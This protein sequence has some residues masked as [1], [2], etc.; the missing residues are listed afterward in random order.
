MPVGYGR[1]RPLAFQAMSDYCEDAVAMVQSHID[2]FDSIDDATSAGAVS[3]DE[4][5]INILVSR[6]R[7]WENMQ[8]HPM[9][10]AIHHLNRGGVIGNS[11]NLN[12]MLS[13]VVKLSLS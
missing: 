9:L 7:A 10:V 1:V 13:T 5:I 12:I 2:R 6:G 11:C 4:D 8:I 3:V